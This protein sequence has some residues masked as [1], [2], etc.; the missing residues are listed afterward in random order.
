MSFE[1]L[2][3]ETCQARTGVDGE[4]AHDRHRLGILA[5]ATEHGSHPCLELA[6]AKWFDQVVVGSG[7]ESPDDVFLD[8]S[9]G[10][11]DDRDGADRPDH[12]EQ[13]ETVEVGKA[14]VENHE[15]GSPLHRRFQTLH[16]GGC[17]D[18]IVAVTGEDARH[19][20]AY[21]E[22]VLDQHHSG[23][24]IRLSVRFPFAGPL[25]RP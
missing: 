7:I 10:G 16:G 17:G 19:Q 14:Q 8:T 12:L 6:G 23:H 2:V 3:V 24:V 5:T 4:P 9:G 11:D 1:L 22:I 21:L 15:V 25:T 13:L 20:V 18:D